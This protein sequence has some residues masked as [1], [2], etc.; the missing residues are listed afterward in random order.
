MFF[1]SFF[2]MFYS[3]ILFFFKVFV[4]I[5][6]VEIAGTGKKPVNGSIN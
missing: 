6:K 3:F 4:C 2:F 1:L 5:A